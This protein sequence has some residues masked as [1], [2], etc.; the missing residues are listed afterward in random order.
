MC[1]STHFNF[2]PFF[3]FFFTLTI[4]QETKSNSPNAAKLARPYL[5][6]NFTHLTPL[7]SSTRIKV[8]GLKY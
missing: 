4:R 2:C 1:T 8:L 6:I 7:L 3:H 5:C